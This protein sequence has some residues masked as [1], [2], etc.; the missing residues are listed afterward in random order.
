MKIKICEECR[1]FLAMSV[2]TDKKIQQHGR[3]GGHTTSYGVEPVDQKAP[4]TKR[5]NKN[6]EPVNRVRI[7]K[8]HHGQRGRAPK[9]WE[10]RRARM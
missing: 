8:T 6:V 2:P 7:D 1:A 9:A 3:L 5:G 10:G 4:R